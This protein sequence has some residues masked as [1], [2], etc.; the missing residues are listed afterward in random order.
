MEGQVMSLRL[1]LLLLCA[2]AAGA[3]ERVSILNIKYVDAKPEERKEVKRAVE[4]AVAEGQ[5][6]LV[7][8]GMVKTVDAQLLSDEC[9]ADHR[10]W[11]QTAHRLLADLL[12]TGTVAHTAEGW[13][14]TFVPFARDLGH[15]EK[16]IEARCLRC[17]ASTFAGIAHD[18]ILDLIR[19]NRE[20]ARANLVLR[21]H[22]PDAALKVD[23]RDEGKAE[24]DLTVEAGPHTIEA[25]LPGRLPAK[26]S[27]TLAPGQRLE[28][29]L[30]LPEP[31]VVKPP[32]PLPPPVEVGWRTPRNFRI[33]GGALLGVGAIC[34][35]T[36]VSL[37]AIDGDVHGHHL[38]ARNQYVEERWSNAPGG[39]A[40]IGIG[41]AAAV[42]SVVPFYFARRAQV[43]A[44][45]G[46]GGMMASVEGRF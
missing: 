23:G 14:A 34:L 30:E 46:P 38:D 35:I 45:A 16:S 15:P 21:S 39:Y 33:I 11:V 40:L 32:P 22:P 5:A 36:G 37:T 27:E 43:R 28:L 42:S 29:M 10:C 2:G 13:E 25:T 19:A 20:L 26:K 18:R 4:G 8:E 24:Q 12:I 17:G 31:V 6:E 1:G 7:S 9:Q 41:I 44:A 3:K